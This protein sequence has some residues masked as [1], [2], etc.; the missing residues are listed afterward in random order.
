MS[1]RDLK[2]S[3]SDF[4]KIEGFDF[5]VHAP[6]L[7][8]ND[9]IID[10]GSAD[11]AHR[12]QSIINLQE[13]VDVTRALK[14]HFPKTN[15]P[16]VVLNV[17]GWSKHRFM[18]A[19]EAKKCENLIAEGLEELDSKGVTLAIQTMPPFPWHF[20]GQG[21]CNFFT[22]PDAIVRFC[23][24]YNVKVCLDVSHCLMSSSYF[25]FKLDECISKVAP[26]VVHIHISDADGVDGEGVVFGQGDL[27]LDNV[28]PTLQEYCPSIQ[29][30]PEIWQGHNNSGMGFWDALMRLNRL[31]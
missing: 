27:D 29:F 26:Y 2:L 28:L 8:E 24:A 7:F 23:E 31:L 5:A 19:E 21:Y 11:P 25:G 1:S 4:L 17:G 6:D 12:E 20:G 16:V 9:H 3:P 14:H 10:L 13:V 30:L 18:T 15:D 22:N